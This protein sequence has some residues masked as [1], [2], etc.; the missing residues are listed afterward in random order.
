MTLVFRDDV[1]AP[2]QFSGLKFKAIQDARCAERH[3]S[4]T[5]DAGSGSWSF[6]GNCREIASFVGVRPQHVSTQQFVT[7]DQ[8]LFAVLLHRHRP[9]ALHSEAAPSR[10]VRMSP[11]LLWRV[12]DPIPRQI[13]TFRERRVAKGPK[14]LRKTIGEIWRAPINE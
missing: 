10:S 2:D 6:A 7:D 9:M 12:S 3:N 11:E 8:L 14:E 1:F 13:G 4:A 5:D